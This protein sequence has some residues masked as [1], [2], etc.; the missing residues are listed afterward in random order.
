MFS[1]WR[2]LL[3]F[4]AVDYIQRLLD[5]KNELKNRVRDLQVNLGESADGDESVR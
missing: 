5:Q 4:I 1:D 2:I 3:Y